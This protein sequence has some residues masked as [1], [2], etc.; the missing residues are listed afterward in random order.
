MPKK[1]QAAARC[2]GPQKAFVSRRRRAQGKI[3]ASSPE[4]H[5]M[6]FPVEMKPCLPEG[7]TLLTA[8]RVFLR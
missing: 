5:L 1:E 6:P 4:T 2:I 8:R 7:Y 3:L